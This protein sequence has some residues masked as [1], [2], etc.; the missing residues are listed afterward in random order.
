[1]SDT[2]PRATSP[3]PASHGRP[4]E[5]MEVDKGFGPLRRANHH[6]LVPQSAASE[7][8]A[9]L[10]NHPADVFMPLCPRRRERHGRLRIES[11][12][13]GDQRERRANQRLRSLLLAKGCRRASDREKDAG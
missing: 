11:M 5:R 4:D 8:T 3:T 10:T 9:R 2:S 7:A 1:L 12:G 6:R 13:I